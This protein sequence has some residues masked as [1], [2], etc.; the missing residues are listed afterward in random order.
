[1]NF[2]L[3]F[4]ER[5]KEIKIGNEG[6]LKKKNA[7]FRLS[8]SFCETLTTCPPHLIRVEFFNVENRGKLISFLDD[9]RLTLKDLYE[10]V[11]HNPIEKM[12]IEID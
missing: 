7:D 6:W 1:M 8:N 4:S 2:A 5:I 12:N 10:V 11:L 9:N 3:K